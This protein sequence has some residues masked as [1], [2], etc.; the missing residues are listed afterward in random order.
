MLLQQQPPPQQEAKCRYH[1]AVIM[2]MIMNQD[3]RKL[4]GLNRQMILNHYKPV[5]AN[6]VRVAIL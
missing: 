4:I 1:V 5:S 3:S 2:I 6:D